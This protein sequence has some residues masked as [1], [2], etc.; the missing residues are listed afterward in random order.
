MTIAIIFGIS[1]IIAAI[2]SILHILFSKKKKNIYFMIL[3]F[4]LAMIAYY[5][6]PDVSE[7]LYRHH[8]DV[9][10]IG[11]LGKDT[12]KYNLINGIEQI[13]YLIKYLVSLSGNVN[14]LQ[15]FVTFI[16]YLIMFYIINKILSKYDISNFSYLLI[17]SFTVCSF[18]YLTIISNLWNTLALLVFSLGLYLEYEEKKSKWLCYLIYISTIFIHSSMVVPFVLIFIFKLMGEKVNFRI[19]ATIA[20]GILCLEPILNFLVT[21]FDASIFLE[22]KSFYN[23][24]FLNEDNFSYLHTT[25]VLVLYLSKLIPYFIA[26]LLIKH[27]HNKMADFS[28]IVMIAILALFVKSTFSIRF[29]PIVQLAG[30]PLLCNIFNKKNKQLHLMLDFILIAL[31]LG[32]SYYQ[33]AQIVNKN[34]IDLNSLLFKNIIDI[35]GQ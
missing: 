26:Y 33:Y 35:F 7:D 17:F 29:I 14:L 2:L 19:I 28:I 34:F 6:I 4:A 18:S 15:F 10:N 22:L 20:I 8:S 16:D 13:S 27:D 9:F 25:S 21:N 11:L 12:V 5:Y 31:L 1:P 3:A 23:N 30:L 32:V 24:Y